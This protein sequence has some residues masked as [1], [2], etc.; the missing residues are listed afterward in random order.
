MNLSKPLNIRKPIN[1][2]FE[3]SEPSSLYG[4]TKLASEKLI[5]EM[6]FN[7]NLKYIID[8]F[9]VIAGPW[10]FGKQDQGFVSLWLAKHFFKQNLSYIGFGGNGNQ[11]RDVIHINDVC[12]IVLMQIKRLNKIYNDTFVIGGGKKNSLSLKE[13]TSKC[14]KITK[15]KINFAK[16]STTS[17]YDIPYFVSNNSKIKKRY[18]WQPSKNIDAILFDIHKWLINNKRLKKFFR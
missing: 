3:T 1:E 2:N 5:K 14:E 15:N 11:I 8:R 17:I 12:E 13:L 18:N 16:I 9:G 4:F 10:Q 7:T 6:F